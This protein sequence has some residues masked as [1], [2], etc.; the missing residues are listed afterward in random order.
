M[1][2][3]LAALTAG[4]ALYDRMGGW[5]FV[6]AAPAVFAATMFLSYER[7]FP[8]QWQA[9]MFTLAFT[10]LCSWRIYAVI[11]SPPPENVI[12]AGG[13]GTV[14][15]VREWGRN[16][17]V[18][19][20]TESRGKYVT[21]LRFDEFMKG[22]RIKFDGETRGFRPKRSGSDFDEG[23]FWRGRGVNGVITLHNTQELPGRWSI[24]MMRA[25]LSR[26]LAIYFP[27]LTG[28]YLRAVWIGERSK[29]LN[30]R[31]RLWGT[32]HLLAVS[33]FHVGVVILCAR[34]FTGGNPVILTVILWLYVLLTGAAPSAMRAGL[35]IQV[36]LCAKFWRR[37]YNGVNSVCAAGVILLTWS[38]FLF[39]DIGW[40]LSVMSALVIA[41]MVHA[42]YSWVMI[43]PAV[44]LVTFP[45][46]AWTFG[47]VPAVGFV[48]NLFAPLYFTFAF[49]VSSAGAFLRLLNLPLTGY[50]MLAV[51]GVFILM[52]KAAESMQAIL[53]QAV[54]WNYALAWTGC[55]TLVFFVCRYLELAPLRT[56]AVMGAVGFMAF[57][58]FL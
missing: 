57:A 55:G 7:D 39:W 9:F 17:A 52:E 21:F 20:E 26:K 38:P 35:M 33:G 34:Y 28:L 36:L 50:F 16:Y 19:I 53:P 49:T 1:M 43:S 13:E 25:K 45:Q 10:L 30:D 2:G 40:R 24:A 14:T 31:H 46:V 51:E 48:L 29:S 8:G 44:G 12:F 23:R 6:I 42:G 4:C 47:S 11:S 41:S 3:V 27:S 5:A 37:N 32:S 54:G 22:T 56:A 58:V 15:D 18:V